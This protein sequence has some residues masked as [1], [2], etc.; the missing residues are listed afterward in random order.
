M[1]PA[2]TSMGVS[3]MPDFCTPQRGVRQDV[4]AALST[5]RSL[6]MSADRVRIERIGGGWKKGTVVRQQPAPGTPIGATTRVI[7]FV[8]APAAVDSLPY[9]MRREQEGM[10]GVVELMP[11]LDAPIAKLESFVRQA[12]G[13][14][15]LRPDDPRT[16]WRWIREIFGVDPGAWPEERLHALA[17]LLPAVHRLAGTE[18]GVRVALRTVFELP[19]LQVDI[20]QRL[21]EMRSA[22]QTR[23]GVANGRLG[24]DA[25]IGDGITAIAQA[26]VTI[27]PITLDTYL[28][29]ATPRIRAHRDVL[30][31][32]MLPSALL[33]PV[34]ERWH[35]TPPERGCVIGGSSDAVRLGINSRLI[36]LRQGHSE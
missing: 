29:H 24:V 11:V 7:L 8:S 10:F 6:A 5:L 27:G 25:V 15:E 28:Q 18:A 16:A 26:R 4:D 9:A 22:L 2:T 13:F 12:G 33:R 17:R 36:P 35:V 20:T 30:Y 32:L 31:A 1:S 14:L 23:L 21:L 19:V 34:E 3:V